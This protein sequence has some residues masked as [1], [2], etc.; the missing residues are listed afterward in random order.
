MCV[1]SSKSRAWNGYMNHMY[2]KY[3]IKVKKKAARKKILINSS[4]MKAFCV[5]VYYIYAEIA[6]SNLMVVR[7]FAFLFHFPRF[8]CFFCPFRFSFLFL[9]FSFLR[10]CFCFVSISLFFLGCL[11][12]SHSCH[13]EVDTSSKNDYMENTR[14]ATTTITNRS[15]LRFTCTCRK[16]SDSPKI[17][18]IFWISRCSIQVKVEVY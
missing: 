4:H 17:E 13:V 1:Y 15:G 16:F 11:T 7:W 18:F 2:I 9:F 14:K 12:I 8:S 10:F 3:N 5:S 6:R